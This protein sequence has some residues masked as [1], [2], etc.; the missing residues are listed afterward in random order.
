M[1]AAAAGVLLLLGCAGLPDRAALPARLPPELL[2]GATPGEIQG[3]A[4]DPDEALALSEPMRR[5]LRESIEPLARLH[6]PREALT[7]ALFDPARLQLRYDASR[8]RSAAEAFEARAGNCLSLVLMTAVLA[9][10]L[11]LP[12]TFQRVDS[13]AAWSRS[14][15]YMAYS[16]HVNLVLG[17]G[18]SAR[19]G[20]SWDTRMTIDFL[21]GEEPAGQR[22]TPISEATVLGMYHNNRAAEALAAG[23]VE[24]AEAQVRASLAQAPRLVAAWNTLALIH[25]R[26]GH[27]ALAERTLVLALA[28]EP[29]NTRVLANLVTLLDAAGRSGDAAPLRERLRRLEPVAPFEHFRRGLAAMAEQRWADAREAFALELARDPDY[30]EFHGWMA[31]AAARLGDAAAVRRHLALARDNGSTPQQQALYAAKLDRLAVRQAP[32]RDPADDAGSGAAR[33]N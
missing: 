19:A 2:P 15:E 13:E 27:E 20:A 32:R 26:R 7:M 25:R 14:G 30:H 11:K 33:V 29:G 22:G 23:R 8:T 24:M 9:R 5:F 28:S 6:G 16:G 17:G 1:L 10:E 31:Q 4:V 3:V 21:P 18:A 12:V